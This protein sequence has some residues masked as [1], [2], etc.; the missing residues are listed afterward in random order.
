MTAVD[1]PYLLG[2]RGPFL[3][4]LVGAV[5]VIGFFAV[6]TGL[7]YWWVI[8]LKGREFMQRWGLVRFGL[9]SFLFLNMWAVVIKMLLRH[10]ASIKYVWVTPWLNI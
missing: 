7:M 4:S 5:I 2:A 10:L 8:R 1:L 9:T 3:E 6:G